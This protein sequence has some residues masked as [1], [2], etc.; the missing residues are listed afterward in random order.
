MMCDFVLKGDRLIG[1]IAFQSL[2]QVWERIGAGEGNR[3]L[4]D[5]QSPSIADRRSVEGMYGG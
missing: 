2:S 4:V 3:T 5:C 1:R